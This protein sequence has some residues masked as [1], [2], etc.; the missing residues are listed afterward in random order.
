MTKTL[1]YLLG[2]LCTTLLVGC[3]GLQSKF[4][5]V[6]VLSAERLGS[7]GLE[8]QVR[9]ENR[10]RHPLK[11]EQGEVV[12]HY[13]A[14]PLLRGELRGEVLFEGRSDKPV[15]TRWKLHSNDPGALLLAEKLLLE[16]RY[17]ELSAD[18]RLEVRW[19]GVKRS[20]SAQ[21]VPLRETLSTF[22][23]TTTPLSTDPD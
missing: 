7:S 21:M 12:L 6:E 19:R 9:L 11:I 3:G 14:E 4:G 5:L 20:F 17:E 22:E 2:L 10:T 23:V 16:R 13:Q 18:Y 1:K 8:L 15:T